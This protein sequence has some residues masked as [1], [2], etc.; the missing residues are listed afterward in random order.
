M[1]RYGDVD[2]PQVIRCR[3]LGRAAPDWA[4]LPSRVAIPARAG[5]AVISSECMRQVTDNVVVHGAM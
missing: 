2:G 5:T 1:S 4:L 3:A